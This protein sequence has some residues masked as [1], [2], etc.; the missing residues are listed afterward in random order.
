MI[1]ATKITV[2]VPMRTP[3]TVRSERNL[4]VRSVSS[5]NHRFSPTA[6]Q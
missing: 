5:A 2:V 4:C 3:S 1:E 6:C